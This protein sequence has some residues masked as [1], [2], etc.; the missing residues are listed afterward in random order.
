MYYFIVNPGSRTGEGRKIWQETEAIL[1]EKRISYEV[2]FT[3]H[4]YHASE[5]TRALCAKGEPFTLVVLGG[6]GTLNEVLQGIT[7]PSLVTLG[8]IPTGSGNDFAK[9]CQMPLDVR[10]CGTEYSVP[11]VC[12]TAG[13]RADSRSVLQKCPTVFR[14]HAYC[15]EIQSL[16]SRQRRH[17]FRRCGMCGGTGLSHQTVSQSDPSGKIYLCG[18]RPAP[19]FFFRTV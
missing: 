18:H 13:H 3:D 8:Y 5:L 17:R 14:A 10:A 2:H 12:K 1:T 19:D 9:G 11:Q 15:P 6:D 16:L 4:K 7:E